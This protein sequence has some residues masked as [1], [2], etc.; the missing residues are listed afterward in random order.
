MV[1]EE[2]DTVDWSKRASVV[3]EEGDETEEDM[4]IWQRQ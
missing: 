4:L 1:V 3:V 2:G